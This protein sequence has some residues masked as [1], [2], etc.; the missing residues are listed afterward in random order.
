MAGIPH[1]QLEVTLR[2]AAGGGLRVA[3]CDQVQDPAEAKGL[4]ARAVTRV[5]TPGTLVE[6]ALLAEAAPSILA[7]AMVEADRACIACVDVST[8]W[9]LIEDGPAA[10]TA[11]TLA[12]RGVRELLVPE[13]A[14]GGEPAWAKELAE[15]LGAVVTARPACSSAP[16]R[17][18]IGSARTTAWRPCRVGLR[19]DDPPAQRGV[20]R[21]PAGDA[22]RR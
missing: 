16:R 20:D 17:A 3:V 8:G 7:A 1:H 10:S 5:C 6:D 21:V 13:S 19:D 22:D 4:V 2:R 18:G 15:A 9:M 12:R 14:E 11:D